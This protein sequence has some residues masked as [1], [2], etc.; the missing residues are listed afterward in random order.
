MAAAPGKTCG[1]C[2]MCCAA[3][4]IAE[5]KKPA[6]PA[7]EHCR[8]GAGCAIYPRRPQVCRDFECEW[9]ADRALPATLRP[10]RVGTILM[11]ADDA[12]EFRAVCAPEKPFAWR[13]PLVFAHLVRIAKAGRI[14]VAKAGLNSWRIFA[15][16]EW[17]PTV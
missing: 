10:D 2:T 13:N 5:L 7:C 14:V 4:E 9:L 17:G 12:D 3:L 11:E 16:G 15:S 1:P 8:A 6:G